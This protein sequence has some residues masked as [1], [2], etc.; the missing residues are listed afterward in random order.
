M[1]PR[2]DF[3]KI[4]ILQITFFSLVLIYLL[5]LLYD[6]FK[7]DSG[8]YIWTIFA[9]ALL[10]IPFGFERL[11]GM[12]F[13][14]EIKIIVVLSLLLHTMG[15]FHRW[16]YT[17]SH[18]D[19]IS[20]ITS[21]IGIAYLIFLFLIFIELYYGLKWKGTH[22]AFFM[23]LIGM[24]FA[25]YWEWWELFSDHYF[26]S[27]FF[28]DLQDG[29]GDTIANSMGA[30]IAAWDANRYLKRRSERDIAGDFL[31]QNQNRRFKIRWEIVPK[32]DDKAASQRITHKGA[33]GVPAASFED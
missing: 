19:K 21:T 15:E 24:S 7:G 12:Y 30:V 10:L 26:G 25:F 32:G 13:P 20:H 9:I 16:Y 3:E 4:K 1:V 28:W 29:I 22:V 17:L 11:S 6:L 23:I 8:R 18:Y 2:D 5:Y 14:W 27:K 33:K 31:M